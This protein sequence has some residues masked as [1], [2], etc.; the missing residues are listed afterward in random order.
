MTKKEI[1]NI[2]YPIQNLVTNQSPSK[3]IPCPNPE[4]NDLIPSAHFYENRIWCFT[5]RQ[6]FYVID[7]IRFYNLDIDKLY[8]E[9]NDIYPGEN[10]EELAA[11]KSIISNENKS[12]QKKQNESFLEFT[13]KYFSLD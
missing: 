4:H 11:K 5:C 3:N 2:L 1:L 13:D 9:L 7:I 6:F 10:L 12:Y 8:Q